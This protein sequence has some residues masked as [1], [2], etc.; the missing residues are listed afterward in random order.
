M[1]HSAFLI[2]VTAFKFFHFPDD[3]RV[4]GLYLTFKKCTGSGSQEQLHLQEAG[5]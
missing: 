4:K 1:T 5:V 2:S 3:E